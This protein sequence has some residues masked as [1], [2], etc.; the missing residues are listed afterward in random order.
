MADN[1]KVREGTAKTRDSAKWLLLALL[2][3]VA[4]WALIVTL[5]IALI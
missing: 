2:F 5:V 4:I 3:S 1:V